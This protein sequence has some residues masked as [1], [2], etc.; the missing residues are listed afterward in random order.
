M[1]DLVHSVRYKTMNRAALAWWIMALLQWMDQPAVHS[2]PPRLFC[3]EI[4]EMKT[5]AWAAAWAPDSLERGIFCKLSEAV[6]GNSDWWKIGETD[7]MGWWTAVSRINL[8]VSG[9]AELTIVSGERLLFQTLVVI[10]P[11]SRMLVRCQPRA[12][13]P[14]ALPRGRRCVWNEVKISGLSNESEQRTRLL[15]YRRKPLNLLL[16]HSIKTTRWMRSKESY[17]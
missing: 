10:L 1:L 15:H 11:P 4:V 6:R 7:C 9:A 16:S 5:M 17:A 12:A 8:S 13:A 14:G 2:E 3:P